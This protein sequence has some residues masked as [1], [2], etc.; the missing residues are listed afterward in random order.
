M[1]EIRIRNFQSIADLTFSVDGFTVVCG[2]NNIGKSA[3]VRAIDSALTNQAGDNYIRLGKKACEVS[4]KKD[5]LNIEWKK[6]D[7]ATYVVNGESFSKLNR[8]VPKPILDAGFREIEIGDKKKSPLIAPQF[9]EIFLLDKSGPIVTEVLSKLYHLDELS[10]ADELC[11][12]DLRTAKSSLK[13]KDQDLV[14]LN[15]KL[16]KFVGFDAVLKDLAEVKRLDA[17]CEALKRQIAEIVDL[18]NKLETSAHRVKTLKKIFDLL[19]PSYDRCEQ[20]LEEYQEIGRFRESFVANQLRVNKLQE[21]FKLDIPKYEDFIDLVAQTE[22]LRNW[23][24][25]LRPLATMVKK[26]RALLKEMTSLE[27]LTKQTE[28][29]DVL[30][31]DLEYLK[32]YSDS[33][34]VLYMSRERV[35]EGLRQTTDHLNKAKE[36]MATFKVCPLCQKAM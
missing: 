35:Y 9:D 6:G 19:I 30:L 20:Q 3:I 34:T 18:K 26:R 31:K 15:K 36:E 14:D 22:A 17:E 8:A 25:A 11:Q 24:D 28:S 29:T 4:F 2:K 23:N 32:G 1:T 13:T 27:D 10:T 21:I 12:K 16:E 5:A 7:T 33:Y